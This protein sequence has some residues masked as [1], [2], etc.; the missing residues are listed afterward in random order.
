MMRSSRIH[1][2]TVPQQANSLPSESPSQSIKSCKS[3]KSIQLPS[4]Q[5]PIS[6]SEKAAIEMTHAFSNRQSTPPL[7]RG[8]IETVLPLFPT[9]VTNLPYSAHQSL[10]FRTMN[11]R[12]TKSEP[13]VIIL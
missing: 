1:T 4:S 2:D 12:L 10:N 6:N 9:S 13:V 8:G 7:N 5:R 11:Q 3:T